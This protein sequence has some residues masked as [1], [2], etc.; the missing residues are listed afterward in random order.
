LDHERYL[1]RLD[2][3]EF[4]EIRQL[5][6]IF[7]LN[8]SKRERAVCV[9]ENIEDDADANKKALVV[10][11]AMKRLEAR[12]ADLEAKR[13]EMKSLEQEVTKIFMI[14]GRGAPIIE[15]NWN[16][17]VQRQTEICGLLGIKSLPAWTLEMRRPPGILE[18]CLSKAAFFIS[19]IESRS[20]NIAAAMGS[21]AYKVFMA[22]IPLLRHYL[23]QFDISRVDSKPFRLSILYRL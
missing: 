18:E 8:G 23:D 13:A 17:V 3:E 7:E 9:Y 1:E 15:W 14:R 2:A 10:A 16:N 5:R 21:D 22:L 19:F 4:A 11:K 12:Y 6:E 20:E